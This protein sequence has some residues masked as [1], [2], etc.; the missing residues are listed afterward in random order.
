MIVFFLNLFYGIIWT[1]KC[2]NTALNLPLFLHHKK[3]GFDTHTKFDQLALNAEDFERILTEP[4]AALT[5]QYKAL[6][7][8]EGFS[9]SFT[10]DGV[11]QI[12]KSAFYVNENAENI[13][14]RRLHTI[15][16]RLLEDISFS[17]PDKAGESVSLDAA[18]VNDKLGKLIENEDLS[19]YIL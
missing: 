1:E 14:A 5:V 15:M 13:G 3:L 8:T 10:E 11:K 12:A 19:R 17:A 2:T 6:M 4:D 7:D 16:E 9:I 18:Y